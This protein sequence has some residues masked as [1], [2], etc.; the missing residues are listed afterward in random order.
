MRGGTSIFVGDSGAFDDV[1]K[2]MV[3]SE[4]NFLVSKRISSQVHRR[5][6]YFWG[7]VGP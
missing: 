2:E 6:L 4:A 5:S 7:P 1:D 3:V